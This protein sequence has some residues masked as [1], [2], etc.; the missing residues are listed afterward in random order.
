MPHRT[1]RLLMIVAA[2]VVV[3]TCAAPATKTRVSFPQGGDLSALGLAPCD[4]SQR[5]IL[6]A[7][8][9]PLTLLVHGCN[10]S[11]G[12]FRILS[13]VFEEHGQQTVCFNYN[14]RD[15]LET[16]ARQLRKAIASLLERQGRPEL[17]ILGHSQGGLVSRRALVREGNT[18]PI[19]PQE[20]AIRLVTVSSP[21]DGIKASA[22]CGSLG[23]RV[24]TLGLTAAICRL[25]VGSKWNEIH[26]RAEFIR[27]P[28]LLEEAV[29]IHIAVQTDELGTCLR[30]D[31]QGRCAQGDFVF[32]LEE[33]HNASIEAD[34][35]VASRK[36]A[37][38]HSEVVGQ[39]GAAPWKLIRLLQAEKILNETP[40]E[41]RE[42][43]AR[44]IE[45]L[46]AEHAS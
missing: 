23:Y 13:Q 33:Q 35:R 34:R 10:A 4:P 9:R 3:S 16:S 42:S 28:G 7:P 29:N 43:I 39:D 18:S 31:D 14:D 21:F 19:H 44:L 15:S 17:N 22:D 30:R 27:A 8:N 41:K 25:A 46:F 1:V 12:K 2:C 40:P 32:S 37:A 5:E 45:A 11:G 38:G 36:L 26:P 20:A 6:L 24:L